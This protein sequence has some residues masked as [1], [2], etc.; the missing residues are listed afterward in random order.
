MPTVSQSIDRIRQELNERK[1]RPNGA[2]N[3]N[4]LRF[5]DEDVI[6][7]IKASLRNM[8]LTTSTAFF[9]LDS[10]DDPLSD[11]ISGLT[12]DDDMPIHP[13]FIHAVEDKAIAYIERRNIEGA[14]PQ[15]IVQAEQ[16]QGDT[17]G[18]N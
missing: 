7:E 11:K 9:L 14:R 4:P 16:T 6:T 17:G 8:T 5:S 12:A 18:N 13:E 2:P 1:T 10:E 3:P 15:V